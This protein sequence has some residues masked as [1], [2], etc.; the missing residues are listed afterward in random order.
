MDWEGIEREQKILVEVGGINPYYRLGKKEW[1]RKGGGGTIQNSL[2]LR[3]DCVRQTYIS[4]PVLRNIFCS[5]GR[6]GGGQL[7]EHK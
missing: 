1:R 7:G 3:L 2:K 5:V 6:G 4:G